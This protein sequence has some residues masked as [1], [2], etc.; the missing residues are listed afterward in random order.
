MNLS[1]LH[2]E[3]QWFKDEEG[4]V[5][6]LRGVNLGADGKCP[7]TPNEPTYIPTDFSCHR[8]V[9]FIG[10]PF[11]L[12]DADE[13]FSRLKAWGFNVLRFVITWEAIEHAGP[14]QY[15]TEYLDYYA[16]IWKADLQYTVTL[17]VEDPIRGKVDENISYIK[18][19][20]V[21]LDK[22]HN[23]S[24]EISRRDKVFAEDKGVK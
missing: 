21:V 7:Y 18:S 10:R 23:R 13:H 4:R 19:M 20:Y 11:L 24:R 14:K 3:G 17:E 2:I 16:K 22:D 15:D 6:I 9:S 1:K 12:E 5:V 8:E